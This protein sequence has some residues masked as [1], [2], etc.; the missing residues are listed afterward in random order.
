MR[1]KTV[2]V[3]IALFLATTVSGVPQQRFVPDGLTEVG[4]GRF[5]GV[6]RDWEGDSD[7]TAIAGTYTVDLILGQ[8]AG[9]S[10]AFLS[11]NFNFFDTDIAINGFIPT[12]IDL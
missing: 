4:E 1:G 3:L 10:S 2:L 6:N 8:F 7:G 5:L 12:T 11:C 9:V